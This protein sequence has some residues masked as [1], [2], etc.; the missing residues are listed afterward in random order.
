MLEWI[1]FSIGSSSAP[2]LL[3]YYNVS[4]LGIPTGVFVNYCGGDRPTV[5]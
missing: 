5:G 1:E 4:L 3:N 2:D